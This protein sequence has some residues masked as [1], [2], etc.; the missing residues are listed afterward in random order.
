LFLSTLKAYFQGRKNLFEG[1]AIMELEKDWLEYPVFHIDMSVGLIT[2]AASFY[3]RMGVVLTRFEEQWG[4]TTD[5]SDVASRLEAVIMQAHKQTGRKVVV[6]VDEY[7]KPLLGTIDAPAANED[8]RKAMKVFYSVLKSADDDLRFIFLTGVTKFPKISIFS[9]INQ[10]KDISMSGQYAGIC[11]ISESELLRDFQPELQALAEELGLTR[12][13]AFV[14]MKKRYDGYHFAAKSEDMYNPFSVLNTFDDKKFKYYWF[15]TG[16]PTFLVNMLKASDFDIPTLE[17][18]IK[19][20]EKAIMDY[21]TDSGNFI[22]LL[23]QSGYLTIKDYDDKLKIYTLGF[24]NEEVRYGFYDELLMAY[25]PEK[26][27]QGEF[28][29]EMFVN[30]LSAHD[31]EGFMTRLKAFF[32][33]I[34]YELN[35]RE[36]KHYQTVFYILFKLMGQH[37]EVERRTAVGRMDAVVATDDSVFVFEF[38]LTENATAEDALRQIDEKGYLIPF[39]ASGK[40]LVKIG[41]KFSAGE[42]GIG[43]WIIKR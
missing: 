28:S 1:L 19:I 21:R 34:P 23:Y 31:A 24:P 10:L 13:E 40:R 20:R 7:D 36:E 42:R 38:K 14:E 12:G 22:P 5:D 32:A 3:R 9:D 41:V 16:T 37:I 29:A 18:D 2:D 8:I 39:T 35:N 17:N 15:E 6:L 33:D 43:R 25:M 30:D 26:D 4:R 11:G 27:T